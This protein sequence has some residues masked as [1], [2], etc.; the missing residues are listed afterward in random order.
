M[1]PQT[2]MVILMSCL[3]PGLLTRRRL[4][5]GTLAWHTVERRGSSAHIFLMGSVLAIV[6]T[7]VVLAVCWAI[8]P[9]LLPMGVSFR[10][11]VIAKALFGMLLAAIVTPWAILRVLRE[12]A[13]L[14]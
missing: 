12:N 9:D 2:F 1:A 10:S 13:S 11:L 4:A 3:V 6:G 8:L 14:S 5:A 7:V